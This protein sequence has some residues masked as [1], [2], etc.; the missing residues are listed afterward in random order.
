MGQQRLGE[1]HPAAFYLDAVR[2]VPHAQPYKLLAGDAREVTV[3]EENPDEVYQRLQPLIDQPDKAADAV[4]HIVYRRFVDMYSE[5]AAALDHGPEAGQAQS[6]LLEL[7][8]RRNVVQPVVDEVARK[9]RE[10]S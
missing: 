7:F 1:E 10:L 2:A 5:S 8:R 6:T 9:V 4:G 3:A